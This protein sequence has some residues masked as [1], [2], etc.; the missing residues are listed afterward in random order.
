MNTIDELLNKELR[1]RNAELE[2]ENARLTA[3]VESARMAYDSM[4]EDF[5]TALR[6]M[7]EYRNLAES[8][9]AK[10]SAARADVAKYAAAFYDLY[11]AIG[12]MEHNAGHSTDDPEI[13]TWIN[14]QPHAETVEYIQRETIRLEYKYDDLFKSAAQMSA[15][16]PVRGLEKTES[17]P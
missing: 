6:H 12:V 3:D 8:S 1:A 5:R 14:G 4:S 9:Q 13:A 17:A 11:A 2:A 7:N 10:H 16:I 15:P